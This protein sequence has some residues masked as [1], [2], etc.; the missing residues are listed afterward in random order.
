MWRVRHPGLDGHERRLATMAYGTRT[1]HY[2]VKKLVAVGVAVQQ[3]ATSFVDRVN[4]PPMYDRHHDWIKVH[5]FL[6]QDIFIT[7]GA[8]SVGG[9]R[10]NTP[11][12]VSFLRR[13]ARMYGGMPRRD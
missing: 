9:V 11:K 4:I 5:A 3:R 13:T 10:R 1:G 8:G 2:R 7:P 6:S 12:R